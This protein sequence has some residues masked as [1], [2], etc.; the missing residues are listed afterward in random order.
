MASIEDAKWLLLALEF[1]INRN[2]IIEIAVDKANY[3]RDMI[4]QYANTEKEYSLANLVFYRNYRALHDYYD[5]IADYKEKLLVK[6]K[7]ILNE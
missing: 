4:M 1:G 2:T 7:N 3:K 5:R 6:I